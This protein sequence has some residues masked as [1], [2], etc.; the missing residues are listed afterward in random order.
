MQQYPLDQLH[1]WNKDQQD[2]RASAS[3]ILKKTENY[4]YPSLYP[5]RNLFALTR[6]QKI[7]AEVPSPPDQRMSCEFFS[8]YMPPMKE[9]FFN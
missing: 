2:L 8:A 4:L 5:A 6:N 9:N 7:I 3:E 1:I